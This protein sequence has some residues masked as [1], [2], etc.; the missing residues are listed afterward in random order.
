MINAFEEID[1]YSAELDADTQVDATNIMQ[2]Q[3]SAPNVRHKWLY[4]LVMAK[5]A[6]IKLDEQKE[7]IISEKLN[8]SN[9]PVSN[10]AARKNIERSP[11]IASIDKSIRCQELLVDYLDSAVKQMNQIGFD[12]K[13]LVE[14]MKLEQL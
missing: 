9:L 14:L 12:Y 3:L 8:I 4:R 6:L 10:L 11:E 13:N 2:R 7:A 1:K 5:K